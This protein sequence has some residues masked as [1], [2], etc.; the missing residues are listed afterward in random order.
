MTSPK[1]Q[2]PSARRL[3]LGKAGFHR[4]GPYRKLVAVPAGLRRTARTASSE[5]DSGLNGVAPSWLEPRFPLVNALLNELFRLEHYGMVSEFYR[6]PRVS[7]G[8]R[9]SLRKAR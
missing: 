1:R 3:A 6:P 8:H 4:H 9:S 5:R 7:R 2:S